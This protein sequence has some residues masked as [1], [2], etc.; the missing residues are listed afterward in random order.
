MRARASTIIVFSAIFGMSA[1]RPGHAHAD[2]L[3]TVLGLSSLEGDDE[4]AQNL[5]G[6]VRHEVS[7]VAGWQL[8]ER[9]VT[10]AQMLLAHGCDDEPDA[11][12]LGRIAATLSTERVVYG[13]IRRQ[14][15]E[16]FQVALSLFHAGAQRIE[17]TI[18]ESL[19]SRRT[20]IDDLRAAA[21]ELVRRLSGPPAPATVTTGA[22][23]VQ[24]STPL[25]TVRIDG[26]IFG[27]TDA[28]GQ[29]T[30]PRAPLGAHEIE[31]NAEGYEPQRE[32]VTITREA[33][34]T[35]VFEEGRPVRAADSEDDAIGIPDDDR[36][37]TSDHGPSISWPGVALLAAGV[38]SLGGAIYSW[39]RLDAI[40]SDSGYQVYAR[41]F[42]SY[43]EPL[44]P[45]PLPNGRADNC[46]QAAAGETFGGAVTAADARHVNGLCDE[47]STLEVLQYVFVGI[48]AAATAAGVVLWVLDGSGDSA[49]EPTV[50]LMP[51]FGTDGASLRLRMR[52]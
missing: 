19:P 51:S 44:G 41:A 26:E 8:S 38:L 29:L 3:V 1:L 48:A 47:G 13:T 31:L 46:G 36:P 25:A 40:N 45:N 49:E 43:Y 2:A 6:A 10:L 18:E 4:F 27:A 15:G 39:A 9:E 14:D 30:I 28:S 32:Q 5:T 52:F 22:L 50:S 16:R 24:S 34:S 37:T 11:A 20:D 21:R 7:Q 12:C 35:V 42:R 17:R 23:R 33:E